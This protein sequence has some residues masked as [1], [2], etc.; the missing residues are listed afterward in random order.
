M[1]GE[2]AVEVG[3]VLVGVATVVVGEV[4]GPRDIDHAPLAEF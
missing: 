3:D 1:V 2:A 4:E